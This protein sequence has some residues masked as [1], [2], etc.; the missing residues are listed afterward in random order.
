MEVIDF[1]GE[2]ISGNE[3]TGI[4]H[5]TEFR[6]GRNLGDVVRKN[7]RQKMAHLQ[8]FG[9]A[10]GKQNATN[11]TRTCTRSRRLSCWPGSTD[12]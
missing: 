7:N 6:H 2:A 1:D 4:G 11:A 12:T 10:W 9:E 3:Y 8:N 5:V